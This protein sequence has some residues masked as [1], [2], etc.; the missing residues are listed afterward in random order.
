[1]T[2][3]EHC[4]LLLAFG[5]VLFV[6][7]QS[8]ERIVAAVEKLARTRGFRVEVMP[9]WGELQVEVRDQYGRLFSQ[10]EN[11]TGVD[12]QR[13]AAAISTIENVEAGRLAPDSA[14]PAINAIAKAPLHPTWLF[15]LAAAAGAVA[16]AVVY[17]IEHL[18]AA[19]LILVS[20]AAGAVV[21]RALARRT[22]NVFVQPLC[23]ALL[24]GII[25]GL[26]VRCDLSS[27]LR[28]VAVCPCMVLVP[29]PHLLNGVLDLV[30]GRI[31]LGA[32]RLL[33]ALL[34]VVAIS[35]GLLFGLAIMGVSLPVDPTGRPVPLWQDVL[36]A[37]VA[38]FAFSVFFSMPLRMLAW[39]LAIGMLAHALRW[40]AVSVLGMG[41]ATGAL[42]ACFVGGAILTPVSL[43]RHMPF[44][45]IGFASV[46][47]LM[48]GTYIFRM[49]SGLVQIAGALPTTPAL[50]SEIVANG[51]TALMIILAMSVGL[52]LP[53]MLIESVYE[54]R[55]RTRSLETK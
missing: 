3:Q 8:T 29:G 16:L 33:Y 4:E 51:V 53:K 7:G 44:A 14:V 15:A 22:A 1:M 27:S 30:N 24:A 52:I 32:A 13:V 34:V 9:R 37:G 35:A 49:A 20:A 38:V 46:V 39:P 28:L 55:Q 2:L 12:M 25:G 48:P 45:A 23:A 47:S 11:P 18:A 42:A 36:A 26:A 41:V 31:H 54:K 40:A 17:G 50:L 5:R 19:G 21:R 6:N 43:R 10:V